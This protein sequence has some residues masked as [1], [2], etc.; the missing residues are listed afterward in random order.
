M[1]KTS[2]SSPLL[3]FAQ[4]AVGSISRVWFVAEEEDDSRV[5]QLR[6]G[7]WAVR[8]P[9]WHVSS[10][11]GREYA[12]DRFEMLAL[13]IDGELLV[14][15]PGGFT[16]SH[17]DPQGQNRGRGVL[18]DIRIVGED[19]F[20]AGMSRQV[21]RRQRG[22]WSHVS[23]PI[24]PP[25]G[26]MKGFNSIAGS[27]ANA[28]FAVGYDGEVWFY[29]GRLWKQLDSPTSVALHR[30]ISLPSGHAVICG[31]AGVLLQATPGGIAT[32]RNDA[33]TDNLYGLAVFKGK[34]Y[35]S[36]LTALYAIGPNG[37]E[38]MDTGLTGPLTFGSL[39][40]SENELWSAGAGHLLKTQDGVA[41]SLVHCPV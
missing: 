18:R 28:V 2:R 3:T 4:C 29:D 27:A 38:P 6:G 8:T 17:V 5:L 31:A 26:Q 37:L 9:E 12:G 11:C 1:A 24:Q 34:V 25:P 20:A 39:D 41:W 19:V 30:V 21:Y 15:V 33:T 16:E 10:V 13:G 32:V 22:N 14:G 23:G 35:V 7:K 40:A 36:S